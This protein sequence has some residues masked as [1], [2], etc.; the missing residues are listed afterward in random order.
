MNYFSES[1]FVIRYWK[2]NV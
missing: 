1:D 2:L